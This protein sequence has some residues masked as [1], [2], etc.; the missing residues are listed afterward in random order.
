MGEPMPRAKKCKT[1]KRSFKPFNS[2]QRTCSVKCAI[3][4][5]KKQQEKNDRKRLKEFRIK[6]RTLG[7]WHKINQPKFNRFIRLRDHDKPCISCGRYDEEINYSGIGGKWDCGHYLT[8]GAHG[9]LRYVEINA[10]K[11]CKSCN[12][13]TYYHA[14]KN[15]T[16]SQNYRENLIE[17]IGLEKVEWL[18]GPHPLKHWTAEEIQE[19]GKIYAAKARDLEKELGL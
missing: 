13:G 7:D 10:H 17:R 5:G 4:D 8:I 3:E 12:S 15:K 18:E 1:C 16:V 9:H 6:N 2:L 19:I 14:K 11:Q